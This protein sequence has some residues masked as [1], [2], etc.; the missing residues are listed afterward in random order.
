MCQ[1][2]LVQDKQGQ[3]YEEKHKEK[4]LKVIE[5]RIQKNKG[6]LQKE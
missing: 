1:Q 5:L 3:E 2:L 6:E 4:H